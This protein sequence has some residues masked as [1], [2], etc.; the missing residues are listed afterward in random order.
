MR[1]AADHPADQ[2]PHRD[3]PQARYRAAIGALLATLAAFP[4]Q[5]QTLLV[6]IIGAGPRAI[7]RRDRALATIADYIDSTNER[8]AARGLVPRLASP[9][10]AFA[11][12]G[13]VVELASRQLRTRTPEQLS[14]LEPVVQRLVIGIL[15]A[16][17]Q[18]AAT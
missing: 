4:D 14:E 10:D 15:A 7:E 1:A 18:Q 12:V 13:A 5:A 8:D 2:D 6:E 9:L 11:L 17:A 16:S 3:D